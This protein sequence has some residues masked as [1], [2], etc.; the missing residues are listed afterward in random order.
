MDT[1]YDVKQADLLTAAKAMHEA[2]DRLFATLII[3][4]PK[5]RPSNSGQPWRA[6]SIGTAAIRA[7]DPVWNSVESAM[8]SPHTNF[9]GGCGALGVTC[10]ENAKERL[11][12][13]TILSNLSTRQM[14]S[15]D[16]KNK[17]LLAVRS[18]IMESDNPT[19]AVNKI[20]EILG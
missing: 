13:G 11:I 8:P 7:I 10:C 5:F 12:T 4:A 15:L 9:C 20:M 6:I 14:E 17:M 16:R 18:A 19:Q 1:N 2:I 3:C